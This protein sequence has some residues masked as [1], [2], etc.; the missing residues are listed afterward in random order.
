MVALHWHLS[1]KGAYVETGGISAEEI[2]SALLDDEAVGNLPARLAESF[3]GR[4][5]VVHW[6][7][8]DGSADILA[9]S[10]YFSDEQLLRYTSE[11][12][13]LDP[14]A[15]GASRRQANE[16]LDLEAL[17]PAT[18]YE[19]SVFY[20]EFIRPMGDDTYRCMGVR[21]E[22]SDGVGM[23]AIQRGK[24]QDAYEPEHVARLSEAT[25]HLRRLLAVR[26]KFA[27]LQH[28]S[29]K[30]ESILDFMPHA[31][32]VVD[33][34]QKLT[35]ANT[36]AEAL[37]RRADAIAVKSGRLCG[38]G[39]N[40]GRLLKRALEVACAQS[41]TSSAVLLE[42]PS[43]KPLPATIMPFSACARH[44]LIIVQDATHTNA[45]LITQLQAFFGLTAAEALIG[46][47]LADGLSL[48]DIAAMR[49]V[50]LATVRAQLKS[51]LQKM[52][53]HR[54]SELVAVMKDIV[55]VPPQI[56]DRS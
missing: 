37:L 48:P 3:G 29:K 32:F 53:C 5:T 14:W 55:P 50:S 16:A 47:R 39:R 1:Q 30:L 25:V 46:T 51:L 23:I 41:P 49:G 2:Y 42:R 4:S 43:G 31:V 44:A 28:Q 45:G 9:H 8:H 54:Q 19:R 13:A 33:Q 21:I 34:S 11:F 18:L 56:V 12:A 40:S 7:H 52:D 36:A 22:N 15:E 6:H 35:I 24:G 10:K 38:V 17:V 20:N 26:G 27:A